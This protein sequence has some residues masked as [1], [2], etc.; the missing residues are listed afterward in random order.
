[1]NTDADKVTPREVQAALSRVGLHCNY[2]YVEQVLEKL[3][4]PANKPS[5]NAV[6]GWVAVYL[7]AKGY[8]P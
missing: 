5:R 4:V 2:A 8:R 7:K 6:E 3:L 1:M